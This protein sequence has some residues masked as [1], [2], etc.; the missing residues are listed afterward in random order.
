[1]G[2]F[3]DQDIERGVLESAAEVGAVTLHVLRTLHGAEE[4]CLQ[5][6]ERER[7]FVRAAAT[8]LAEHRARELPAPWP[9]LTGQLLDL[10]PSRVCEAKEGADLVERLA[11]RVVPC[12]T[13]DPV[14]PPGGDIKELGVAAAHEQPDEGRSEGRVLQRGREEVPF[15]MMDAE[16]RLAQRPGQPLAVHRPDEEGADQSRALG[17]RDPVDRLERGTRFA[18]RLVDDVRQGSE[19]GPTRQLRDHAAE[20][21]VHVL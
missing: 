20:Y 5:A 3:L 1:M 6:A 13:D 18:E 2:R 17:R 19:M 21:A 10:R 12:G 8:Q 4:R 16:E 11:D 14:L 7:I 9:P 15:H